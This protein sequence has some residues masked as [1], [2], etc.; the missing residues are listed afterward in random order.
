MS[1]LRGG[2]GRPLPTA[3]RSFSRC[4]IVGI[5]SQNRIPIDQRLFVPVELFKQ[6]SKFAPCCKIRRAE[7]KGIGQLLKLRG[8]TSCRLA[9]RAQPVVRRISFLK[10]HTPISL[11]CSQLQVAR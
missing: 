1:L 4:K 11:R 2:T 9:A 6:R 5:V 10:G 8:P 7:N 3:S